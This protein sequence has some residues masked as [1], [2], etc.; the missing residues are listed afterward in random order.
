M[1][2]ILTAV[3]AFTLASLPLA[4][5]AADQTF[6]FTG[7]TSQGTF[8]ATATL[9]VENGFAVSGMGTITGDGF[10]VGQ[11]LQLVTYNTDGAIHD[12][13][14]NFGLQSNGGDNLD[15]YD[16]AIPVTSTGGVL[17]AVGP[18][19]V[20]KG[21]SL[22]FG[23]FQNGA[24]YGNQ[25]Y[26]TSA[27]GFRFYETNANGTSVVQ[28]SAAPEPGTW[29]L[30]MLGVGLIGVTLGARK[31]AVRAHEARLAAAA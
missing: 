18:Q 23:V 12:A 17:F 25:V 14:G 30:M 9:D 1:R 19:A 11:V 8:S 16:D 13:D 3:A 5:R 15:E 29:A 20:S 27:T 10:G 24:D 28:T 2:T 21:S 31:R 6:Q 4:A 7:A 26:G 22:L